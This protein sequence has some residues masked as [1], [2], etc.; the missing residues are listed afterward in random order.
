MEVTVSVRHFTINNEIRQYAAEAA[1]N[2]FSEF[3]L[4]ISAINMVLDMQRNLITATL[5]VAIKDNPVSAV[6][7]AYDNVYK[8]IDE[9]VEK[10]SIQ[11]RKYLDKKQDHAKVGL[12]DEEVQKAGN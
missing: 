6:S 4:K 3:R 11:A 5:T 1:E 10:A 2:A 7:S 8:A 12:K 9:A